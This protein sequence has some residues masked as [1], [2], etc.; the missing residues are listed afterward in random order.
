MDSI[1]AG[2]KVDILEQGKWIGPFKVQA[3]GGRTQDHIILSGPNGGFEMYND[4]PF[5]IRHHEY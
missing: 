5:N 2:D 1:K 4:F 3:V